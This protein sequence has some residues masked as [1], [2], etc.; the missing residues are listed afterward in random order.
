MT[1]RSSIPFIT[2]PNLPRF[3]ACGA[4]FLGR[5]ALKSDMATVK[6]LTKATQHILLK[7]MEVGNPRNGSMEVGRPQREMHPMMQSLC[8]FCVSKTSDGGIVCR[9][10]GMIIRYSR[11]SKTYIALCLEVR[12]LQKICL[13]FLFCLE[14]LTSHILGEMDPI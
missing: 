4:A 3:Q 2:F 6:A 8:R 10:L 7:A 1:L 9:R 11:W 14:R 12:L 5:L 13:C